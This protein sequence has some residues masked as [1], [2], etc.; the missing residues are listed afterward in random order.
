MK[1]LLAVS[2]LCISYAA[3]PAAASDMSR[4]AFRPMQK[5]TKSIEIDLTK[6]WPAID[7]I[8]PVE[9]STVSGIKIKK[10]E[11]GQLIIKVCGT[12]IRILYP[13]SQ[14]P[15]AQEPQTQKPQDIDN[16]ENTFQDKK[17][18]SNEKE[19]D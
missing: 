5:Q 2:L 9:N 18:T 12:E 13:P 15:Q 8:N 3:M 4:D 16:T 7:N 10:I 1:K 19:T 6:H 17:Q 14:E 11:A